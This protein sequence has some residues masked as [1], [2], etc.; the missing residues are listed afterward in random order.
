MDKE[1]I[2][3]CAKDVREMFEKNYGVTYFGNPFEIISKTGAIIIR[4]PNN[5]SLQGF[6]LKKGDYKCI[7]INSNDVLGRQHYSCWHEFFH[8]ID[9]RNDEKLMI[10]MKQDKSE[11][12]EEAEYFASCMLLDRRELEN[13]IRKK[14]RSH[15]NLKQEDL[16]E[17]QYKFN[18]SFQAL[19]RRLMDI[20]GEEERYYT[21]TINSKANRKIYE[22]S[23][24]KMGYGLELVSSTEDFC[25]PNSFIE[26]IKYNIINKRIELEKANEIFKFLEEKEAEVKW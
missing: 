14:W 7:Y 19:K 3:S 20:Y 16:I 18:V 25:I 4:F 26:D 10:S 23:I 8:S 1:L 11:I 22:E 5:K 6:T 15:K 2:E 21:F 12:E 13:Y 24:K 9:D 17:I